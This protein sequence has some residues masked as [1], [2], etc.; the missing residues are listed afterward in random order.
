MQHSQTSPTRARLLNACPLFSRCEGEAYEWVPF[1]GASAPTLAEVSIE[2]Q[3][4]D[5]LSAGAPPLAVDCAGLGRLVSKWLFGSVI[6][7]NELLIVPHNGVQLVLRVSHMVSMAAA[8]AEA[9]EEAEGG[10]GGEVRHHLAFSKG[11][12]L[13]WCRALTWHSSPA[14]PFAAPD[15]PLLVTGQQGNPSP[16]C[17][18]LSWARNACVESSREKSTEFRHGTKLG[19]T[20]CYTILPLSIVYDSYC[21]TGW[22]GE[23]LYC[24][25]V[26]A[27]KGGSG[28][29]KQGGCLRTIVL[30]LV[31][32]PRTKRISC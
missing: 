8:E 1:D 26:W 24:A 4:L 7:D 18:Q 6:A 32:R 14:R 30:I 31:E 21:N 22:S 19:R 29:P 27:M 12:A 5:P 11:F 9:A 25:F 28:V 16:A 17:G 13:T 10:A 23:T 3:L 2:A 15:V 20:L